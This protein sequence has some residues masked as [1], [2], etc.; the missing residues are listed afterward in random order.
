MM[1]NYYKYEVFDTRDGRTVALVR[2]RIEARGIVN[3]G[4]KRGVSYAFD[5][6]EKKG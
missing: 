5:S 6:T 4:L 3:L 1:S 2:T